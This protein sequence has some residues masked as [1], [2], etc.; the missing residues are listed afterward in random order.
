MIVVPGQGLF[1]HNFEQGLDSKTIHTPVTPGQ[2]IV[3]ATVRSG[4]T[5]LVFAGLTFLGLG[6]PPPQ[7]SW[8]LMLNEA[9]DLMETAPW[10]AVFPGLA[11]F[12]TVLGVNLLGDGL[13]DVLDPRLADK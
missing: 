1:V 4:Y 7:P 13:R 6:P 9:K 2:L 3:M 11:I 12:I 8:G 5:L 10:I